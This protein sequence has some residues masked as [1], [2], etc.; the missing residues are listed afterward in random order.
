[1]G[2]ATENNGD[3][4]GRKIPR[5]PCS[6]PAGRTLRLAKPERDV[7]RL[8]RLLNHIDE[9]NRQPVE[10]DLITKDAA[11][12]R[13]HLLG[14][15][16]APVEAPVDESLDARAQRLDQGGNYQ[17]GD[18]DRQTIPLAYEQAED[19]FEHDHAAHVDRHARRRKGTVD[20][21]PVEDNL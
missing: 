8:H 1:E 16:L 6:S 15:V 4:A 2:I 19:P 5:R 7:S 10:I 20:Q 9:S 13:Q 12:G 3:G 21:G 14:V 18:D 17:G 11:E